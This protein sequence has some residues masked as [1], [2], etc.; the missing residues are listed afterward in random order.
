MKK[1]RLA[2]IFDIINSGNIETQEELQARLRDCGFEVTQATVS[3]DI[4]EL[5]LVKELSE[6]GKYVYTTGVRNNSEDANLSSNRIFR[7]SV[8]G[9]D[10]AMNIVCIKCAVGMANAACAAIDKMH[11][12]GVVGTV[13]G[14]DTIF[15]LCRNEKAAVAFTSN[16]EKILNV[17][18]S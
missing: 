5:R 8:I 2:K 7:E 4:K 11:W 1:R 18:N 15:V 13:A 6:S 10:S 14:D 17:K 9:I 16:L 12:A 3:R